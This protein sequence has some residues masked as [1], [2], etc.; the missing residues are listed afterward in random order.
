MSIDFTLSAEVRSDTGKGASRRL[1][2][3]NKVPAILYGGVG[4]PVMLSL[5]ANEVTRNLQE[6][7]FYSHVLTLDVD[8]KSEQAILR[9]IQRHPSKSII[10]HMDFLRVVANQAITVQVPLHFINEDTCVGVKMGGGL[11]SHTMT[12]LEVTCLPKD[13]PE[14]IEVDLADVDVGQSVHISDIKLPSGV[15]SVALAHGE[16]H[17]LAVAAVNARKGGGGGDQADDAGDDAEAGEADD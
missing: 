14:Y 8:G 4:E 13:L 9:D 3:D 6:E 5:K 15:T 7:A 1:R 16:E 10:L 2:R 12:E 11:I 17:D